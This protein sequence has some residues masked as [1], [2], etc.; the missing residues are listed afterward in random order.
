MNVLIA[1]RLFGCDARLRLLSTS[2]TGTPYA[3]CYCPD[4][5]HTHEP[6][7]FF[8]LPRYSETVADAWLV[9]EQWD[10]DCDLRRQNHQWRAEFFRPSQQWSALAD[11][12][13]LA[14]CQAALAASQQPDWIC[15]FCFTTINGK[16][17][18]EWDWILQSAVCPACIKRVARDGGY[19][20]VNGGSYAT[21]PDPRPWPSS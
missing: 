11:T 8:S 2:G 18:P 12:L 4:Q 10:G 5:K 13:P 20:V 17:P 1:Q 16:L 7:F 19:A 21:V 9:V 14:I 3:A 6:Q 15:E